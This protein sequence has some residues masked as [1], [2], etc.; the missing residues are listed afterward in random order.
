MK[1]LIT[2]FFLFIVLIS[3]TSFIDS[4]E[5]TE[6]NIGIK[7]VITYNIENTIVFRSKK[8][9]IQYFRNKQFNQ[10]LII[11]KKQHD[12]LDLIIQPGK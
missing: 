8:D 2:Y 11:L 6:P 5:Y 1:N 10:K 12:M 9:S 4:H 7:H 3:F